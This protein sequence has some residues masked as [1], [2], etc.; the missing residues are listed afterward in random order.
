[1]A[2]QYGMHLMG[3]ANAFWHNLAESL[4]VTLKPDNIHVGTVIVCGRV[5]EGDA[6]HSPEL[7]GA[8]FLALYEQAPE[9]WTAKIIY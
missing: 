4:H 5:Q 1:M 9:A 8:Q 6:K 2:G 7:V 3:G